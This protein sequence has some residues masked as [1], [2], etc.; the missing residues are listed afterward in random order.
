MFYQIDKNDFLHIFSIS[1]DNFEDLRG[2]LDK[3]PPSVVEYHLSMLEL[4]DESV[5]SFSLSIKDIFSYGIYNIVIDYEDNLYLEINRDY[6]TS[7][8][9]SFW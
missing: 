7:D 6:S 5:E 2:V 8:T 4:S 3:E 9:A 1:N